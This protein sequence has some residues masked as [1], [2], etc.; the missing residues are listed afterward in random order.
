MITDLAL[1]KQATVQGLVQDFL[2]KDSLPCM[3]VYGDGSGSTL[4]EKQYISLED[5]NSFQKFA[6]ANKIGYHFTVEVVNGKLAV[7]H[8]FTPHLVEADYPST[9]EAKQEKGECPT[10]TEA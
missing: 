7:K 1:K 6:K 2:G 5:V 9:V 10:K 3:Q 8:F 4:Y